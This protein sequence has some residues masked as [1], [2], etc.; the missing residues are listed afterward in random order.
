MRAIR[1]RPT[2]AAARVYHKRAECFL[3][4]CRT[5]LLSEWGDATPYV[6]VGRENSGSIELYN[7]D[8]L[9]QRNV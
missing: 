4:S 9:D 1:F 3:N 7:E 5:T 2:I 8:R 6:N